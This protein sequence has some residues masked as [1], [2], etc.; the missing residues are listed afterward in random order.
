MCE[1]SHL[2]NHIGLLYIATKVAFIKRFYYDHYE[3]YPKAG[4]G[5]A[6]LPL[7]KNLQTRTI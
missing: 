1:A 4:T 2:P 3:N 6:M 7:K 5:G